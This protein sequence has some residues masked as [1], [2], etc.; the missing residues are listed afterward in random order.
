MGLA[1]FVSGPRIIEPLMT[2]WVDGLALRPVD[3]LVTYEDNIVPGTGN[4]VLTSKL[5]SQLFV[6][7]PFEIV[8]IVT[9][10]PVTTLDG[11][12][13]S[14]VSVMDSYSVPATI[15]SD[16]IGYVFAAPKAGYAVKVSATN[17]YIEASGGTVYKIVPT[18]TVVGGE[19]APIV[20]TVAV[21]TVNEGIGNFNAMMLTDSNNGALFELTAAEGSGGL[22]AGTIKLYGVKYRTL[23]DGIIGYSEISIAE[24]KTVT[25][26][27]SKVTWNP[28]LG[29]VGTTDQKYSIY[30]VYAVYEYTVGDDTNKVVCQGLYGSNPTLNDA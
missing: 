4:V 16:D 15:K 12:T 19:L 18:N 27:D 13:A 22:M 8:G 21:T 3:Y 10:T 23:D 25:E 7:I 26:G 20:V 9:V 5:N 24:T 1:A 28:T 29:K 2:V 11:E 6:K 14:I 30:Y 17:A